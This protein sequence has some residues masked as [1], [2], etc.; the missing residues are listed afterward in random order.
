MRKEDKPFKKSG[1]F[2]Q[3]HFVAKEIQFSIAMLT[4]LALLGGIFLQAVSSALIEYWGFKTPLLGVFL[5][6]GY[7]I[8]VV[9]LAMFFTHRLVGPFK[10]LEYEMR[11]IAGGDI[12]KRL[13]IRSQDDLHIRNFVKYTNNFINNFMDMSE[14]YNKLNSVALKKMDEIWEELSK[15]DYCCADV[16]KDIRVL[17]EQI[18][19]LRKKW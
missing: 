17:Q 3:R 15:E 10:R 6:V 19:S 12:S 9:I 18:R 8:I 2:K 5:I 11:L 16:Q 7:I 14:E 13:S 1:P 4:V